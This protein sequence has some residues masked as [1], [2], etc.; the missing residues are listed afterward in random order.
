MRKVIDILVAF[1][2]AALAVPA[3]AQSLHEQP[4]GTR[5]TGNF[6][7]GAVTV[8]LPQGEWTLT[9]RGKP[10]VNGA[11]GRIDIAE[12]YLTEAIE[13]KSA[14]TVYARANFK[15]QGSGF[16]WVRD[17]NVCDRKNVVHVISDQ[18]FNAK[19][20]KCW[21]VNHVIDS[22]PSNPSEA[23]QE[24]FRTLTERKWMFPKLRIVADFYLTDSNNQVFARYSVDPEVAGVPQ[25]SVARWE[26]SEWNV[27]RIGHF[28]ERVAFVD[29]M[30][31]YGE[32]MLP[33]V[34]K[35]LV[36]RIPVGQYA[37]LTLQGWPT[38]P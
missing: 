7:L 10:T 5:V 6:Q 18:N 11:H 26:S 19:D 23:F 32:E 25:G 15:G 24:N 33:L 13:G 34:A 9:G 17:K 12:V 1:A 37:P 20:T 28:P 14:R 31:I 21:I 3:A 30:R 2:F 16:G 36:G 38:A 35:G 22:S 27:T 4:V 8:P 29:K